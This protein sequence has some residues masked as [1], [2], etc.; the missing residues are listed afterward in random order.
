MAD[1]QRERKRRAL[2]RLALHPDPPTMQLDEL[3]GEGQ[4]EAS[5]L[6]LLVRPSYLPELLEDRLLV[7]RRDT[8]TSVSDRD[9][10]YAFVERGA[11]I[12]PA[13]L[14]RELESVGQEI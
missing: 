10:G 14:G 2:S 1:R 3:T 7:L 5:A 8:Y 9:L 12:D 4:P 6:D 11:D 13:A